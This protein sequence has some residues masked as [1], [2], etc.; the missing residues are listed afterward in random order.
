M[1]MDTGAVHS[2]KK[3]VEQQAAAEAVQKSVSLAN[4]GLLFCKVPA[5]L[6]A[7]IVAKATAD[8]TPVKPVALAAPAQAPAGPTTSG[9]LAG[10]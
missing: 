2:R 7:A 4:S 6:Q 8:H 3:A 9:D 5:P 10:S 1:V